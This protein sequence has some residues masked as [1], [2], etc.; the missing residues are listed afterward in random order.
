MMGE[1]KAWDEVYWRAQERTARCREPLAAAAPER[2]GGGLVV[3]GSVQGVE[4]VMMD[5]W[6]AVGSLQIFVSSQWCCQLGNI[7]LFICC[8]LGREEAMHYSCK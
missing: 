5:V 3:E 7:W 1:G 6:Y 8:H 2:E 4:G